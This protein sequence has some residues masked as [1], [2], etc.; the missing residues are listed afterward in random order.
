MR[1]VFSFIILFIFFHFGRAQK[2]SERI[3]WEKYMQLQSPRWDS[4]STDYYTGI[5]LGNG[6]LGTNIYKE[7]DQAVRFD[8]GRS[9]VTEHRPHYLDSLGNNSLIT[10]ARLPIGKMLLNTKGKIIDAQMQLDIYNASA[11][12]TITTTVGKIYVEAV[13]PTGE[14]I[15]IIK[16]KG[17]GAE[18]NIQWQW[19][20]EKSIS[21]RISFGSIKPKDGQYIP[22]PPE[23]LKDSAGFSIC[24]QN[25]FYDGEYATVWKNVVNSNGSKMM[26]AVG[27][28][29]VAKGKAIPQAIQFIQSATSKKEA[30]IIQKHQQWWHHYFQQSF[31]SIPD[32]RMQ[33]YYWLVMYNMGAATHKGTT[34]IDLMGPW[35]TAKTPWPGIW[36]NLNTQL[37]YSSI[38]TSNHLEMGMPLFETLKNNKSNLIKNVPEEWQYDAAAIGRTSGYD[39][40]SPLSNAFIKT[41]HAEAGNLTW[42]LFYYYQYF[43]YS[44]DTTE[45]KNHIIPLLK[46]SVNFLIH[47]LQ[48]DEQGIYHLIKTHSPEYA[49]VEDANY[50][51]ST[52]RWGLKTLIYTDSLLQLNDPAKDKWKEIQKNLVAYP[53]NEDGFMIGKDKPLSSSHRHFSHLMMIYPFREIKPDNKADKA[54]I[55]KSIAH[56]QSMPNALAGYSYVGASSMYSL[57]GNGNE[58]YSALNNFIVRHGEANC[59]YRESGPCSETPMAMAN[60]LLEML[61]QSKDDVIKIFPSI[62]DNWKNISFK[63][64]TTEGAFLISASR[65]KGK[66]DFIQIESKK[67][68]EIQISTEIPAAQINVY[69]E[70][71]HKIG[72]KISTVDRFTVVQLAVKKGTKVMI[73]DKLIS[74]TLTIQPVRTEKFSNNYWGLQKENTMKR[75]KERKGM[76]PK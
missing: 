32:A 35:S 8:I 51:L 30:A 16:A 48:K 65:K 28:S 34:L 49:D 19:V 39:L 9:D 37:V 25:L 4:I 53:C 67:G 38:F 69:D 6:L 17:S 5:L 31:I 15:I 50:T 33:A 52:L 44:G 59:L 27:N 18:K 42:T 14:Q 47:L 60:S 20:A 2:V 71:Q 43:L 76:F 36:W 41:G 24:Y 54:L 45:L 62:P 64:L 55:E 74:S 1:A 72:C 70:H 11:T 7:N 68:G 63:N 40:V 10:R 56:W 12:A 21:P 3:D 29:E 13:V 46:R 22:N 23:Q 26:I 66:T 58:A 75:L 61:L 73:T 57:L